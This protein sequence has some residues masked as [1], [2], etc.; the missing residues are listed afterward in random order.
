MASIKREEIV[1]GI[2]FAAGLPG[3]FRN[4]VTPALARKDL[5]AR[6][7]HRKDDFLRFVRETIYRNPN[8]PY[9]KLLRQADFQFDDL[10][11]LVVKEGVQG[12][13]KAM[14]HEGV[15]LTLDEFKGRVPVVRGTSTFDV[16]PSV[17]RN[18]LSM[19]SVR[20]Q[21]S[22]SSG[23]RVSVVLDLS[24]VKK[25]SIDH[26]MLLEA[27]GGLGWAHAIWGVPGFADTLRLLELTS[28]GI[29]PDRWFS[30]IDFDSPELHPRYRWS[31]SVLRNMA[32]LFGPSIP[33]KEYVPWN[34]PTPI[35]RWLNR[36]LERGTTP[37]LI[38]HVGP[39]VRICQTALSQ[40]I[41]IAGSQ[42]T[43]GGEPF[44]TARHEMFHKAGSTV[45]PRMMASECGYIG[46]GCLRPCSVDDM[47]VIDDMNTVISLKEKDALGG[48]PAN[49]VLIS[50]MR[51][52]APVVL[53]NVSL[54]DQ[55][56]VDQ[57]SCGC[58]LEKLGWTTHIREV[59]SF[60]RLTAGGMT[61]NDKDVERVLEHVL[62]ARFGGT[63][64]D[65][66]IIES[67]GS[68]GDPRISLV[69]SPSVGA[70]DE[71]AL[72]STFIDSIGFGSGPERI[73]GRQWKTG[74]LVSVK[75]RPPSMTAS[76]KVLRV[77]S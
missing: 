15:Y 7:K 40:N 59:R 30:Q 22:G 47:H 16:N 23:S 65:Y 57:K 76:G 4:R 37:H 11:A 71:A 45:L 41:D 9:L 24:F 6:L 33:A 32:R 5:E 64:L 52:N 19:P 39:G 42:F 18:P 14:Y 50:S 3:F 8:S 26:C 58:H 34:D 54:G 69:V 70:I 27:R 72:A 56:I 55:A 51:P 49:A 75:R 36:S 67:E 1:A 53:L 28:C 43:I 73:M 68:D 20:T 2:R 31:S 10:H 63:P 29:S 77:I 38:T 25:R 12:S 21:T 62:P 61:F 60:K 74:K 17:L 13:L 46:Y 66:Q 44:T 48:L 35:A